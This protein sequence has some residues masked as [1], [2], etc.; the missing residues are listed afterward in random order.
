[1]RKLKIIFIVLGLIILVTASYSFGFGAGKIGEYFRPT[2]GY[3][4]TNQEKGKPK[5]LDFSLFWKVWDEVHQKYVGDIN[6]EKLIQ[7]AMNGILEGLDDPY[8]M[9]LKPEQSRELLDELSGS[10][11]GIGVELVVRDHYL[12]VLAPLKDSPAERAG[13]K[14]KDVILK[15]DDKDATKMTFE[16]A[17]SAIRGKP[18][19]KVKLTVMRQGLEAVQEFEI[20]RIEI[21]GT[22]VMFEIKDDVAIL[23][24]RQFG[25]DT[26]DLLKKYAEEIKANKNIKGVVV[27]LRNNPGGYLDSAVDSSSIFIE[28]GIIVYEEHKDGKK[29]EYKAKG[30]A[31][32]GSYPLSILI[33]EGSASASEI[34]AGAIK[35]YKKGTLIGKKTYGK[36]SV[37]ELETIGNGLYLKIT[38]AKWLTP[39]GQVINGEGIQP[40]IEVDLTDADI[41]ADRDPQLDRAI[42]EIK[43]K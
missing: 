33:N 32:L 10:F 26:A 42:R 16:E 2:V 40:D 7:G 8:S 19:T 1:M 38:V 14:P 30:A 25:E 24:I 15:I 22:N 29:I 28:D 11:G 4:I 23:R 5:E 35:D 13:L 31:T 21:T 20:E 37:Q 36:G 18:G 12:T 43:N 41:K 9:V 3:I 6:D 17:V 34:M 27:D 39:N